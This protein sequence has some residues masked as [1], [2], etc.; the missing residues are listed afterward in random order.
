MSVRLELK[1]FLRQDK[2]SINYVTDDIKLFDVIINFFKSSE[3]VIRNFKLCRFETNIRLFVIAL[4]VSNL[5]KMVNI[6]E[7]KVIMPDLMI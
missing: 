4:N 5:I 3:H 2:L 7:I 6:P 1:M